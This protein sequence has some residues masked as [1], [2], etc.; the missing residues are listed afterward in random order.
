M[1]ASRTDPAVLHRIVLTISTSVLPLIRFLTP[2]IHIGSAPIATCPVGTLM[3]PSPGKTAGA[4]RRVMG[5]LAFCDTT[6]K[7]HLP[8]PFRPLFL[9]RGF[10]GRDSATPLSRIGLRETPFADWSPRN[11]F[12]GLECF[13]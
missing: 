12:R 9:V 4:L 2:A 11:P 6:A 13:W 1:L 5:Q 10:I 8:S 7:V 3:P